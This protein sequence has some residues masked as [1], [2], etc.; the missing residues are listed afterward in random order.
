[1]GRVITPNAKQPV[2][3][4][5]KAIQQMHALKGQGRG[6]QCVLGAAGLHGDFMKTKGH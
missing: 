5:V 6:A 3:A 4:M 1:M 2:T